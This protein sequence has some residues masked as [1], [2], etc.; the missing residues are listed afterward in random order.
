M[1]G[2]T[3]LSNYRSWLDAVGTPIAVQQKLMRHSDI[4]TTMNIYG[5]VVTDE[6]AQAHSK[7]VGLAL[8]RKVI[9]K[10][11]AG[12]AKSFKNGGESGIRIHQ[13]TEFQRVVRNDEHPKALK[14]IPRTCYCPL[15][16]PRKL[17]CPRQSAWRC[18]QDG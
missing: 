5:D 9:G 14:E 7:V 4:R 15:N 17:K 10:L 16:A 8:T 13:K 1:V 6:M 3:R 18:D 2:G 12:L 11:I